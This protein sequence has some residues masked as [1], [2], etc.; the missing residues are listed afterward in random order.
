ALLIPIIVLVALCT[1]DQ[2]VTPTKPEFQEVTTSEI[3]QPVETS[4]TEAT[5]FGKIIIEDPN[6][7]GQPVDDDNRLT[8]NRYYSIYFQGESGMINCG[9]GA[10]SNYWKLY[11]INADSDESVLLENQNGYL[12]SQ[13]DSDK[14]QIMIREEGTYELRFYLSKIAY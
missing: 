9:I 3:E 8:K 5:G 11:R 2:E 7:P 13:N 14:S 6:F 1:R 10:F 4:I 12:L